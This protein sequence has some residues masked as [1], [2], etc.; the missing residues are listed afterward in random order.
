MS[1]QPG[2]RDSGEFFTQIALDNQLLTTEQTQT[3]LAELKEHKEKG[4]GS[5]I[6]DIVVDL[7]FLS[8]EQAVL[9]T[10][11][12]DYLRTRQE[13][14]LLSKVLQENEMAEETDIQYALT[15]QDAMYQQGEPSVPRLLDLLVEDEV[16][17]D[18]FV[19]QL[20]RI[21]SDIRQTIAS[22]QVQ[23]SDDP[24]VEYE[25][26]EAG[27]D[28]GEAHEVEVPSDQVDPEPS[29]EDQTGPDSSNSGAP[30]SDL[31]TVDS[32]RPE[33]G[34][35]RFTDNTTH[36]PRFSDVPQ[37]SGPVAP[38]PLRKKMEEEAQD[39]SGTDRWGKLVC[40]RL[41]G[42]KEKKEPN[43][44]C[45]SKPKKVVRRL[46]PRFTVKDA[47]VHFAEDSLFSSL[48]L[49]EK[50]LPLVDLS[51][52]GLGMITRRQLAIGERIKLVLHVPALNEDLHAKAEV[53]NCE[54]VDKITQH[55]KIGVKFL[56]LKRPVRNSIQQLAKDPA[57]RYK[58]KLKRYVQDDN[59]W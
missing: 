30:E 57:L 48:D 35:S 1:D 25:I 40:D 45:P 16:I 20:Q 17:A 42:E 15:L 7:G 50:A 14:L 37:G 24:S 49:L 2:P 54:T 41:N 58:G 31:L 53:R 46:H 34:S 32:G 43:L 3:C 47:T 38:A 33:L 13:D 55:F 56:K 19:P 59:D 10:R 44:L 12:K 22:G 52:G 39:G 27:D 9:V 4:D 23:V 6:E 29:A 5:N 11:G 28:E 36:T 26:P 51:L 21:V 18:C 8:R